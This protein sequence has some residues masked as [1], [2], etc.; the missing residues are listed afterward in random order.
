MN[1]K[2]II[3]TLG[4]YRSNFELINSDEHH[5][6]YKWT[7]FEHFKKHFDIDADDFAM[8]FKEA[9]SKTSNL[10]DNSRVCPIN[11]ILKLAQREE[12]TEI[13]RGLFKELFRDDDGDIRLRQ[14]RIEDFRDKINDLLN[15]YEPG[16]WKYSHDFRTVLFYLNLR[17]PEDNYLFKSTQAKDYMY[18]VDFADGFGS[19]ESF[20]LSRY[21]RMCDELYKAVDSDEALVEEHIDDVKLKAPVSQEYVSVQAYK[22]ILVFDIIYCLSTYNLYYKHQLSLNKPPKKTSAVQ[23]KADE[24]LMLN[25]KLLEIS[26]EKA[27]VLAERSQFDDISVNGLKV[28]HK[29]FGE[30]VVACQFEDTVT[31]RFDEKELDFKLPDAFIKGFLYCSDNEVVDLFVDMQELDKKISLLN[32]EIDTLDLKLKRLK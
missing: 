8:M 31:V 25:N 13:V 27:R 7:A 30:G 6:Y 14:S 15:K 11:G 3:D 9:I 22:H 5:E 18:C 32:S 20:D 19:G 16:K 24:K 26:E 10:I 28:L 29:S 21:Y 23:K 2:K 1:N 17:Y 4:A 12:L